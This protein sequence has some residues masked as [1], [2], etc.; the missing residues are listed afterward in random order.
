MLLY[1]QVMLHFTDES[2]VV[3][4]YQGVN[5]ESSVR[6]TETNFCI[7]L[8]KSLSP[9]DPIYFNQHIYVV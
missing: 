2:I 5:V 1:L 4:F 8:L 6:Y 7:S 3:L 9:S